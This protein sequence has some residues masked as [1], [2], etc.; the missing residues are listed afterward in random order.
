MCLMKRGFTLIELLIVMAVIAILAGIMLPHFQGIK[1]E[2]KLSR[3][4]TEISLLKNA[5]ESFAQYQGVYPS[6]ITT[7]LTQSQ[8]KVINKVLA[9]PFK[10][11]ASTTPPTYG[12]ENHTS[13]YIIYSKGLDTI[14]KNWTVQGDTIVKNP[15]CQNVVESNLEIK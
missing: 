11:D 8:P 9:D 2:S 13:Y 14:S 4:E 10:T 6:N 12:Y 7:A 5:V 15:G 3:A 1:D